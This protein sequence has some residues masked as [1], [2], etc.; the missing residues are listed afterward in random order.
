ML[1]SIIIPIY[2][3]EK[4]LAECI[5]SIIRQKFD[6]YEIILVNDASEDNSLSICL[7]YK[8]KYPDKI[9]IINKESNEGLFLARKSGIEISKGDYIIHVDSDDKISED[10]LNILQ[11]YCRNNIEA[12]AFGYIRFSTIN[13]C[14]YKYIIYDKDMYFNEKNIYEWYEKIYWGLVNPIWSKIYRRDIYIKKYKFLLNEKLN[15]GEDLCYTL[16]LEPVKNLIYISQPIYQYRDNNN[17][18]TRNFNINHIFDFLKINRMKLDFLYNI[19]NL[20]SIKIYYYIEEDEYMLLSNIISSC[21]MDSYEDAKKYWSKIE[22]DEECKRIIQI[23][24]SDNRWLNKQ[25]LNFLVKYKSYILYKILRIFL[26]RRFLCYFALKKHI[27][28]KIKKRLLKSV[29]IR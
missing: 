29:I 28:Y 14:L 26:C 11:K 9:T 17:S 19:K 6:D 2:N 18:I 16:S 24:Y 27:Y 4:Y 13:L 10:A 7:T 12:V 8:Y 25:L 3:T 15:Y 22:T 5:E 21:S 1:F 23:I 20:D